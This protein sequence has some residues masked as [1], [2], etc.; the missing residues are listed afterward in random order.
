MNLEIEHKYLVSDDSYKSLAT[1]KIHIIQGYLSREKERTVRIRIADAKAYITIKTQNIGDTRNEFEYEIPMTDADILI[2]A[3]IPP[4]IE[5]TRYIVPFEGFKWEI[6]EFKG[7]LNGLELAEIELPTSETKYTLP[8]FIGENVTGNPK[9]YNSN[10]HN[11][12]H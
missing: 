12:A 7:N 2:K 5:K 3:C 4:V 1:N 9:Y 10:I 11:L 8:P 6:D